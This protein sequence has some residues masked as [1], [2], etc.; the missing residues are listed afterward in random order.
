MFAQAIKFGYPGPLAG[1]IRE[2]VAADG[3]IFWFVGAANAVF[4]TASAPSIAAA[5]AAQH[6]GQELGHAIRFGLLVQVRA[7]LVASMKIDAAPAA[8]CKQARPI[9]ARRNQTLP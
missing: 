1:P 2:A 3:A 5:R 9:A 6:L 7:A 4:M 8:S